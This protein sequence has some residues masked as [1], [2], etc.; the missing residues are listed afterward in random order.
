MGSRARG[1]PPRRRSRP[2][3]LSTTGSLLAWKPAADGSV[4]AITQLGGR[5]YL[6]GT[7]LHVGGR[8]RPRLAAVAASN[9][10]LTPWHPKADGAVRA[11]LPSPTGS[12]VFAGGF[13]THV[14][15]ANTAHLAAIDPVQR[16]TAPLEVAHG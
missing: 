16:R 8:G 12:V 5:V 3:S 4:Y 14:N 11:L 6:G 7:F 10:A 15:G 1:S 13:F 9:G 2:T